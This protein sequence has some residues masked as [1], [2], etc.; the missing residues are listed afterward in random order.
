[1]VVG[2]ST[3]H[4]AIVL[5]DLY[6][7]IILTSWGACKQ[8]RAHADLPR[9]LIF[10]WFPPINIL[11]VYKSCTKHSPLVCPNSQNDPL[12]CLLSRYTQYVAVLGLSVLHL[13]SDELAG[14]LG[15]AALGAHCCYAR[16]LPTAA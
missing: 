5:R 10:D 2:Y 1:M 15:T 8:H 6:M 3:C 12:G 16:H 7:I 9:L 13:L 14:S 4:C 11:S